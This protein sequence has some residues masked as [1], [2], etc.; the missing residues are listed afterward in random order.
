MGWVC[1]VWM[2]VG[3][4]RYVCGGVC[5]CVWVWGCV[6]VCGCVWVCGVWGV[7]VG[8]GGCGVGV[9]VG[10]GGV[11]CHHYCCNFVWQYY[12]FKAVLAS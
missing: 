4:G 7:W 5:G 12:H 8:V 3:G 9:W 11:G 1:G 10:V 2:D 6:C